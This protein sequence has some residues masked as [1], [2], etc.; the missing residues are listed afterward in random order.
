[1]QINIWLQH[2]CAVMVLLV[3]VREIVGPVSYT[4]L[5]CIGPSLGLVEAFDY[6][7]GTSGTLHYKNGNDYVVYDTPSDIFANK[8]AR[9][10]GTI[11]YPG[12]K[13]RNQ[14]VDCLLYTSLLEFL[15]LS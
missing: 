4:H 10:Y 11:V 9:L 1:M 5:S 2:Q 7:D 6:L 14:D 8:D 13:F 12:S 15:N 3:S